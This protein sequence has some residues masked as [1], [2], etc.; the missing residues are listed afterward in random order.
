MAKDNVIDLKKPEPF[1]NDPIT[2]VLR[3]GVPKNTTN[4]HKNYTL[5][6]FQVKTCL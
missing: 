2:D 1:V 3:Q 4:V 6:L 5:L